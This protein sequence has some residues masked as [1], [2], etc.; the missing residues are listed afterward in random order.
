MVEAFAFTRRSRWWL[1]T[2]A[3]IESFLTKCGE[4][5]GRLARAFVAGVQR[6]NT[7]ER[8]VFT[9]PARPVVGSDPDLH[10][11]LNF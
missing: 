10:P 4:T 7:G 6:G 3:M 5:V 8:L 11:P 9:I 1:Y 2:M